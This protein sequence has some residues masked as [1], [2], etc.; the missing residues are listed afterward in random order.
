MSAVRPQEMLKSAKRFLR[1]IL[2]VKFT[3][4]WCLDKRDFARKM[5]QLKTWSWFKQSTIRVQAIS[6]SVTGT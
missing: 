1:K 5:V 4:C 2:L 6:W 3:K